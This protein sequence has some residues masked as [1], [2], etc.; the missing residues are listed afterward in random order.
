MAHEIH[1][2]NG[3]A[4]MAFVGET[5]W[6]GLGQQLTPESTIA[7]WTTAAN[8][9]WE[10]KRTQV[11]FAT[12]D[13]MSAFPERHVLYRSDTHTP[14]AVVGHQY[15]IVQPKEVLEFYTSLTE[16]MGYQM[17]TAGVL[18][19][20]KRYWALA[21]A[22]Q[23]ATIGSDTL[24]LPSQ[25]TLKGD[26]YGRYLLFST[27][28]DGTM[29]TRILETTV[30]VVCNNTLQISGINNRANG[31][32]IPHSRQFDA[33]AIKQEL[34]IHS[35]RTDSFALFMEDLRSFADR[36]LSQKESVNYLINLCGNP[37]LL[38]EDQSTSS[39]SQMQNIYELY[40]NSA[41]GNSFESSQNTLLGMLNAVTEYTDW[42]TNHR[43]TDSRINASWFGSTT[44]LKA[45]AFSLATELVGA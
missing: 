27:A 43:T 31:I 21:S 26:Q 19:G 16:Q 44:T 12:P 14:L 7:E 17:V 40:A 36:R 34:G 5:P 38:L 24:L 30:R 9:D 32:S 3:K 4:S 33:E 13:A 18:F 37:E 35:D 2:L 29:A 22:G 45:K 39:A 1:I 8:M 20:G 10:I 25:Q 11:E 15:K 28:C 41:K 6:H 23:T 42:H